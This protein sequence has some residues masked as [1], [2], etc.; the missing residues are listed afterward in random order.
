ME[1]R[2][3][4]KHITLIFALFLL[5][6]NSIISFAY[7]G[8][9]SI[10]KYVTLFLLGVFCLLRIKVII[11]TKYVKF[12]I[13]VF[14]IAILIILFSYLNQKNNI[15]ERDVFLAS[16]IFSGKIVL[17]T[18]MLE[19]VIESKNIQLLISSFF[20]FSLAFVVVTDILVYLKGS[21]EGNYFIGTKFQVSYLHLQTLLFF[22]LYKKWRL[23]F[24]E[25]IFFVAFTIF[26]IVII[27]KVDCNTSLLG[28]ICLL[29]LALSVNRIKGF[30]ISPITV[31][32]FCIL[33]LLAVY[34]ITNILSVNFIHRF[35]VNVL[36]RDITLTSRVNIFSH[37]NDIMNG[38]WLLGY[39]YG[40][41]YDV[42]M[43]F[44]GAADIQNGIASWILQYGIVVTFLLFV[45]TFVAF[46]KAKKGN[47]YVVT[48]AVVMVYVFIFMGIVEICMDLT[49]L[50]WLILIYICSVGYKDEKVV[51]ILE[52]STYMNLQKKNEGG[53]YYARERC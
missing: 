43:S 9:N 44:A 30:I 49:Y 33:S 48:T 16:I 39:G 27:I 41:E 51:K 37:F 14:T 42:V 18:I 20:W 7:I 25:W 13:L 19:Y 53:V 5:Y 35:I 36:N 6:I 52:C 31:T 38:R 26:T 17:I 29:I 2:I 15:Y 10:L 45:L 21:I 34:C 4:K 1:I 46:L 47:N 11:K 23:Y 22:I 8:D 28:L 50:F 3:N 32:I 24:K 40:S 12:N